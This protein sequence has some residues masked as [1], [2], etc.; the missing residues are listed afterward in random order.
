M[1][2]LME[3]VSMEG[4]REDLFLC[5]SDLTLHLDFGGDF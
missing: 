4:V 1:E 3:E 2:D 5:Y